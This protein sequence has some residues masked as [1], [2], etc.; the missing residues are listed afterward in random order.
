MHVNIS[1]FAELYSQPQLRHCVAAFLFAFPWLCIWLECGGVSF[2]G[3]FDSTGVGC[4]DRELRLEEPG[5]FSI[6]RSTTFLGASTFSGRGM[7]CSLV[8]SVA[9]LLWAQSCRRMWHSC[10]RDAC[11][12]AVSSC[13]S[14]GDWD[15]GTCFGL[16][17][18]WD[19][20]CLTKN[21]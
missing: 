17:F 5:F 2:A 3:D 15:G 10:V 16:S 6:E 11:S 13:I 4:R 19:S 21:V 12:M 1:A 7:R 14:S 18:C 9:V 20:A 8:I